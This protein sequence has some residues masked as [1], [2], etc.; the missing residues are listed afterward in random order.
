MSQTEYQKSL[1][2]AMLYR[3]AKKEIGLLKARVAELE[4]RMDRIDREDAEV[5]ALVRL[6]RE[7]IKR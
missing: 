5:I 6:N 4:E 2:A 7:R 1:A 3:Q